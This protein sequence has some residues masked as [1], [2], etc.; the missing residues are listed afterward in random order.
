MSERELKYVNYLKD[1]YPQL[2]I[3]KIEYNFLDGKHSDV[4][5]V[6]D[7]YVFK[8]AKYDWSVGFLENEVNV[9]NF[10]KRYIT[11]P[12]PKVESLDKGIA[13]FSYIIGQPLYRN[14]LLLLDS[15]VQESIA[16]KIGTFLSQLHSIPLRGEDIKN[17]SKCT[18]ILSREDWLL[19]Y[20]EFQK[21]VFRYCDS[22]SRE[23][24]SSIFKPLLE[25][26]RFLAFQPALIHGDLMPYHFIFNNQANKINSVID[27]GLSGIGDPAYDVGIILDNF[28]ETF[29]KR[30]GKYYKNISAYIDRARFY[31]SVTNLCWAKDV[32]DMLATRDFTNFRIHAKDRDLMPVGSKW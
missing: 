23:Y 13:K 5:F 28:G 8:F 16:E 17:I 29:V 4:V 7:K 9:I 11:M 1:K 27:Y 21:K 6:N 15:R 10:I 24:F 14:N 22:Y 2:E 31:A 19:K 30:I 26:E 25:K 18:N 32:S 20:E 3:L 12:L